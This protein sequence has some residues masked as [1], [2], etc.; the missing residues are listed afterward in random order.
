VSWITISLLDFD[1][2]FASACD[3]TNTRDRYNPRE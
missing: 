3:I 2:H 1:A